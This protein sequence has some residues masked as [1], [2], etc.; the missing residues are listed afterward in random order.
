MIKT[1]SLAVLALV[2]LAI[3]G[4]LVYAATR[5]D[6]FGLQRSTT[7]SAPPEKIFA[8]INDL[9]QFNT[10]N[11]YEKKDPNIQGSYRGPSAGPGAF[12][13][14]DGNKEVGKGSLGITGSSAPDKVRM[15]LD[16]HAPMEAHNEITFTLV[17]LGQV[18]EVTW[19]MQG[20]CPYLGK[21]MGVIFN[22]DTMIGRDFE[23]GLASLKA[24]AERG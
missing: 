4:L 10:W 5:P 17:P 16:M 21:L 9:R 2:V 15:R 1:I 6:T 13:D 8:L 11:P 14:F 12:Y 22:M 19:A 23:A 20:P 7:I 18:T 3:A 24:L